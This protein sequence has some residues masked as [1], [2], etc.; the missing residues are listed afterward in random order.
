MEFIS[1]VLDPILG[2][3]KI[4]T[5]PI[6]IVCSL[7]LFIPQ[8]FT[9][10]LS[11]SDIVEPY[12]NWISLCWLILLGFIIVELFMIIKNSLIKFKSEREIINV[13]KENLMNLSYDQNFIVSY[14]MQKNT[15]SGVSL[16]HIHHEVSDLV[17][18]KII[19][20]T[21]NVG[22]LTMFSFSLTPRVIETL[23]KDRGLLSLIENN[24][25]NENE[26]DRGMLNVRDY[27]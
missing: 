12:Q 6:F 2:K 21:S 20:R 7:I 26:L 13:I 18:K 5:W 9:R 14:L 19:Y 22:M 11:Y 24:S 10:W 15:P 8:K 25:C 16:N 1:K 4:I 23:R 3:I 17:A 27:Y